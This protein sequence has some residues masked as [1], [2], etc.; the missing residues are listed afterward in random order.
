MRPR[1]FGVT[2]VTAPNRFIAFYTVRFLL[3]LVFHV[4]WA[5]GLVFRRT[6]S[7][8]A[9]ATSWFLVWEIGTYFNQCFTFCCFWG[10]FDQV[11]VWWKR[12]FFALTLNTVRTI[13]I[14]RGLTA[15][16]VANKTFDSH[17]L[18]LVIKVFISLPQRIGNKCRVF[19]TIWCWCI[20]TVFKHMASQLVLV[21][22]TLIWSIQLCWWWLILGLNG[23]E[24]N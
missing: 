2:P 23:N 21:H 13:S 12:A 6:I 4:D 3:S 16:D 7:V 22:K 17:I 10:F 11:E 8:I 15:L 20:T 24:A 18:L 19:T 9:W 5:R 1:I 14:W